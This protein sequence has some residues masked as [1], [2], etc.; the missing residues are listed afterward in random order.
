MG[1]ARVLSLKWVS[2]KFLFLFWLK[3]VNNTEGAVLGEG[4][5]GFISHTKITTEATFMDLFHS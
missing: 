1:Q 4:K 5:S 3:E 2:K